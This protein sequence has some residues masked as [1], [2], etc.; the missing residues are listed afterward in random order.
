M[1]LFKHTPTIPQGLREEA[2]ICFNTR[3]EAVLNRVSRAPPSSYVYKGISR[4][5]LTILQYLPSG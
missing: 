1:A 4:V 5:V 3:G 2:A